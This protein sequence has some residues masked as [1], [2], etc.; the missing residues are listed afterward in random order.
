MPSLSEIR[1]ARGYT[2]FELAERIGVSYST[3]RRAELSGE[4]SKKTLGRLTTALGERDLGLRVVDRRR[5]KTSQSVK[6]FYARGQN[7][8]RKHPPSHEEINRWIQ[9]G[10]SEKVIG[11]MAGACFNEAKR[12]C[13]AARLPFNAIE[14][15][16]QEGAIAVLLAIKDYNP[17]KGDF[18]GFCY[19]RIRWHMYRAVD[20][21][22]V[23]RIPSDIK[24][25]VLALIGEKKSWEEVTGGIPDTARI[26][27]HEGADSEA[28]DIS[29]E[30]RAYLSLSGR[31]DLGDDEWEALEDAPSEDEPVSLASEACALG[32]LEKALE[33]L[34]ERA[35]FILKHRFGL[36]GGRPK[37]LHEVGELC[38]VTRERVRQIQ[39]TAC[40]ELKPHLR[41]PFTLHPKIII[42]GRAKHKLDYC[43]S[44]RVKLIL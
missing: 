4:A 41:D 14:D 15:L 5:G 19:Q 1:I 25:D 42:N 10:S 13:L 22:D 9:E 16:L 21:F 36:N 32:D 8:Y 7:R 43:N 27:Q 28:G 17:H 26:Y 24:G 44:F 40:A 12:I 29:R 35:R 39:L 38:D 11:A 30:Y 23:I 2:R 20:Q 3:V 6:G 18:A 34:P 31:Q 33:E 37:T